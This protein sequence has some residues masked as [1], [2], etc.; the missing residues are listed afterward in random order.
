MTDWQTRQYIIISNMLGKKGVKV[1][2][3][4]QN[5]E[6]EIPLFV[7]NHQDYTLEEAKALI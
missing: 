4:Y 6:T 5:F 3:F 2:D 1:D 7:I